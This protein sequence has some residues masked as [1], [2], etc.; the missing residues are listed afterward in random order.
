M[1]EQVDYAKEPELTLGWRIQ[2]A[3]DEGK[4]QHTDL[5]E[6]FEV[7]RGTV[8]R[9][10]RGIGPAPKKFILNEIA[11]MCG[12]SSRWLID[13]PGKGN[14]PPDGDPSHLGESNPG[15][16]HYLRTTMTRIPHLSDTLDRT[17]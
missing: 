9:W 12:V 7:S 3:L 8:S 16:I 15:P 14:R 5:M 6:R 13:G 2:I 4:L 11:V 17:G 1:S 10:C